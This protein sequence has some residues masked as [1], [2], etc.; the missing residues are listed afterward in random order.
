MNLITNITKF[1]NYFEAGVGLNYHGVFYL[2]CG[3]CDKGKYKV[4]QFLI[5]KKEDWI[6]GK[7]EFY[8][9]GL[10]KEFG[11]GPLFLITWQSS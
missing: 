5:L 11:A 4:I 9:D 6:W 2:S 1:F 3:N 7:K 8:Y 10:W